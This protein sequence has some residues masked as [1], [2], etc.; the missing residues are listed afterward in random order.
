MK[1][2]KHFG[3]HFLHDRRII[4][5]II[6][7]IAPSDTQALFEI[8]PGY[9]ALTVPMLEKISNL[10]V[11]EI[12][13]DCVAYLSANTKL[14]IFHEDALK[15]DWCSL[16][17]GSRVFGNLPYNVATE[18]FFRCLDVSDLISDM[19]FMM[20]K[21]VALRLIAEPGTKAYSRLSVMM[22]VRADIEKLFD[23]EAGSFRPAPKVVSSFCRITPKSAQLS[24]QQVKV[25]DNVVTAA[26]SR[27]RKQIHHNLKRWFKKVELENMGIKPDLRAED[28]S[29]N[30]YKNM[31]NNILQ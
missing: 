27:R 11:I 14:K 29:V 21:E 30:E 13:A 16:P 19:H 2:K 7:A 6:A 24:P 5:K 20:Q 4:D 18:I 28:I 31:V 12:D 8:G 1:A 26:F 15:F 9:G 17:K 3:Q 25:L 22:Q 10:S 23:I